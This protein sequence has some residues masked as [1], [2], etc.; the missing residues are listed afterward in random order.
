M[1]HEW[2]TVN[3]YMIKLKK[4]ENKYKIHIEKLYR[5]TQI[6]RPLE[7]S[8]SLDLQFIVKMT[9]LFI[10]LIFNHNK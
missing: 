7:N 1:E 9:N 5:P 6:K 10:T 8:V 4:I 3:F 2:D